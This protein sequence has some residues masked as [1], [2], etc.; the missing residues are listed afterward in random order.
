[1]LNLTTS[2]KSE[3]EYLKM[4]VL[5]TSWLNVYLI[6]TIEWIDTATYYL[7]SIKLQFNELSI[8]HL[9]PLVVKPP[10]LQSLLLD[11][12]KQLPSFLNL[13]ADPENDLYFYYEHLQ[14]TSIVNGQVPDHCDL[15]PAGH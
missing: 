8:G 13:P 12:Q 6:E 7:D 4:F 1:M 9:S 2:V 10:K 3:M 15:T 5:V 11:I 14:C